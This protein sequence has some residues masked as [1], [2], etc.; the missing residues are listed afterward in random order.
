MADSVFHIEVPLTKINSGKV[1]DIYDAGN[2]QLLL[3]TS[4]RL[5]AFDVVLQDPIPGKGQVLNRMSLYWFDRFEKIVPNAVVETDPSKMDCLKGADA[6]V[7]DALNGRCVLMHKA[8]V[9]PVEC[10]VRGWLIGSGFKDY[11]KTGSVC[12]IKLPEGLEKASKLPEL[13]FTPSTKAEQGFHDENISYEEVVEIIGEDHAKQLKDISLAIFKNA[14]DY[15]SEKGI[16][17]ADTKFEFGML[18]GKVTLIDEVLTPDSSRFWPAD[19]VVT[20]KN[21][22]SYDKQIVR[23]WLEGTDWDKTDPAPKLPAEISGKTSDAYWEIF[24]KLTGEER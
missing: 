19:R 22:P 17:I 12:G 8:E 18:D 23:D 15:A 6:E 5:S 3:V 1:R 14:A 13:L 16:V 21:P 7:I 20:G 11:T 9:F 10:I 24:T 4:D 2:N